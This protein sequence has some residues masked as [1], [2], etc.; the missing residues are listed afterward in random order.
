MKEKE[1]E[2]RDKLAENQRIH[3]E[4]S[5][6]RKPLIE[7]SNKASN[8]VRKIN[9]KIASVGQAIYALKHEGETPEVTDHSVV[10]YLERVEGMDMLDI[11]AKVANHKRAVKVGNVIVT[12]RGEEI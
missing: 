2:R 9:K 12:V 6:A 7:E 8:R 4:L 3:R 5:E 1:I 11:R 10:R